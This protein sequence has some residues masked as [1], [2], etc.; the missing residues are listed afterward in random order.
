MKHTTDALV[1]RDLDRNASWLRAL[2]ARL[3]SDAGGAED[4]AQETCLATLQHSP[5]ADRSLRPWLTRVAQNLAA[6]L[7]SREA[8]R[9]TTELRDVA[10]EQPAPDDAAEALEQQKLLIG[11]VE[12]LPDPLRSTLVLRYLHGVPSPEIAARQGIAQATVR[13][14]LK[15]AID[16]LRA[17]LDA[18]NGGERERWTRALV[19]LL[20]PRRSAVKSAAAATIP[21]L[22]LAALGLTLLVIGLLALSE[23]P[24]AV[25]GSDLIAVESS[26]TE[27]PDAATQY[28]AGD[29]NVESRSA[30]A[31]GT[32]SS[33]LQASNGVEYLGLAMVSGFLAD[34]N[35][36]AVGPAQLQLRSEDSREEIEISVDPDGRWS[37]EGVPPG[38]YLIGAEVLPD[39]FVPSWDQW[40][41]RVSTRLRPEDRAQNGPVPTPDYGAVVLVI[42]PGATVTGVALTVYLTARVSG[43]LLDG[44]G[45]PVTD[46]PVRLRGA[47][48]GFVNMYRD[49]HTDS[50]GEFHVDGLW[51]GT[52]ELVAYPDA[53]VGSQSLIQ[54]SF[55]RVGV[56]GGSEEWLEV[57]LGTGGCRVRGRVVDEEGAPF[58][59]LQVLCYRT[60]GTWS[61]RVACVVTD[62][63]GRFKL[64]HM[65]EGTFGLNVGHGAFRFGADL[66]KNRIARWVG[67]TYF[68]LESDGED[69]ELESIVAIRSRPFVLKGRVVPTREG[70]SPR[71]V[72]LELRWSAAGQFDPDQ[73]L[74]DK[75]RRLPVNED[76]SFTWW[77]ETPHPNV[78]LHVSHRSAALPSR[79]IPITPERGGEREMVVEYP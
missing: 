79:V 35:H 71:D 12:E 65:S 40:K 37:L 29:T 20:P 76:G 42:D 18:R 53:G 36:N 10:H 4:L 1:L 54:A 74:M 23:F 9:T 50:H 69:I 38:T 32:E 62:E 24:S 45:N 66:G 55:P 57:R 13:W 7:H 60:P 11:L 75:S 67:P 70:D 48:R 58:S 63:E 78:E 59:G 49:G 21:V 16:R 15:Q 5:S 33:E 39:G 73:K 52:Y 22:A 19:V 14:R 26:A 6:K 56:F 31:T 2:A 28:R 17:E 61:R 44:E 41:P 43:R 30:L 34:Q 46:T 77:C 25:G 8:L 51:P 47:E 68:E 64:L 3:I 27:T 72:R